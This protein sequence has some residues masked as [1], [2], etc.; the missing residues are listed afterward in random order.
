MRRIDERDTTVSHQ[1]TNRRATQKVLKLRQL[2]SRVN[3]INFARIV[4]QINA[5]RSAAGHDDLGHIGQVILTLIILRLDL[6][7]RLEEFLRLEAVDAGVD[8]FALAL[9]LARVSL[10]HDPLKRVL[11]IANDA[12]V[13]GWVFEPDTENRTSRTGIVVM[14]DQGSQRLNAYHRHVAR[15]NQHE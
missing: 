10:F 7:Q 3:T 14:F 5:N 15:Q 13:A 12:S 8:L 4:V 2:R 11:L 1:A 6:T 9:F